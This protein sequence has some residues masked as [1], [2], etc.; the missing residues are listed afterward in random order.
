M[1]YIHTKLPTPKNLLTVFFIRKLAVL[2]FLSTLYTHIHMY[3]AYFIIFLLLGMTKENPVQYH[4][5][6]KWVLFS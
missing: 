2:S 3:S 4:H 5:K 1:F 6:N